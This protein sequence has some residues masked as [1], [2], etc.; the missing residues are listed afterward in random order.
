MKKE[1]AIFKFN[2]G[3]GALLCSC[4]RVI[5]KTGKD[6]TDEEKKAA[7]GD[8]KTKVGPRYCDKCKNTYQ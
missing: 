4:C 5:I 8:G 1:G 7:Y 2:S 6:F 3:L